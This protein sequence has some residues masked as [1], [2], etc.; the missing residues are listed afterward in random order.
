MK[1]RKKEGKFDK[2]YFS[3]ILNKKDRCHYIADELTLI[4]LEESLHEKY[5]NYNGDF[6]RSVTLHEL[7]SRLEKRG[8]KISSHLEIGRTVQS[9]LNIHKIPYEPRKRGPNGAAYSQITYS[10]EKLNELIDCMIGIMKEYS[11]LYSHPYVRGLNP[12]LSS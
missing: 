7:K 6:I 1:K 4:L 2:S 9:F 11:M 10:R 5:L 8:I 3:K 12:Y